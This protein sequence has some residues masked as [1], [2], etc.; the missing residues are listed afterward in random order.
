MFTKRRRDAATRDGCGFLVLT[1]LFTC[2]L[3]ILNCL[4]VSRFYPFLVQEGPE[5][6]RWPRFQQMSMFIAPVALIF[7][8]WWL[9]D[10]IVGLLTPSRKQP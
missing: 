7:C 3:L 9:V 1:C 4:A 6:L 2:L 8:E 5:F 10:L